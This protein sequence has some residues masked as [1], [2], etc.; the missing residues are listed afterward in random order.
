M[1]RRFA[2]AAGLACLALPA[3]GQTFGLGTAQALVT[4]CAPF[5][6]GETEAFAADLPTVPP[7][8][9]DLEVDPARKPAPGQPHPAAFQVVGRKDAAFGLVLPDAAA[10]A[11][12]APGASL[13]VK[14]FK[15][16]VA[17]GPATAS[18]GGLALDPKGLQAFK[19]GATLAVAPGQ[20]RRTYVG[21]FKVTLAYY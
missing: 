16:S 11:L 19:V 6:A 20:P 10:C 8:G 13:R 15:V 4:I 12:T 21:Q 17:G 3:F 14:A 18:P 7:A 5:S 1:T 2:W 9:G